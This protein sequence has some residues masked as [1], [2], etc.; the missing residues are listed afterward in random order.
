[1]VGAPMGIDQ[2]RSPAAEAFEGVDLRRVDYILDDAGDH[3]FRVVRSL[4]G[5]IERPSSRHATGG[6]A[7]I[8][9]K[10]R[11]CGCRWRTRGAVAGG[12]RFAARRSGCLIT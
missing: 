5:M 12:E 7:T 6:R 11:S 9:A 10:T 2:V 4:I 3:T 8:A 1:M